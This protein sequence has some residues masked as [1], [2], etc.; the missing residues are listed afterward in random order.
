MWELKSKVNELVEEYIQDSIKVNSEDVGLDRRCGTIILSSEGGW[1]AVDEHQLKRLE[2]YGGFE[3]IDRDCI[4]A[5]GKYT[6]YDSSAS[7]IEAILDQYD[8]QH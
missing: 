3:Y 1:V 8:S 7:R 6:F 2:Y 5:I 4:T